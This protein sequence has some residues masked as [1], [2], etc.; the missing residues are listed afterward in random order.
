[1]NVTTP[2]YFSKFKDATWGNQSNNSRVNW[3]ITRYAD[4]LLMQSEALYRINAND[5][6]RF[7]GINLVRARVMPG[8]ANELNATNTPTPESFVAALVN[9]RGWELCME[10][11]RRWDL[12]RLGSIR[13]VIQTIKNIDTKSN[14]PLLPIPDNEKALNPNL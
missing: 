1:M 13:Q 8:A 5:P 11:H 12:I 4:V 3:L 14:N 2:L 6:N 7:N 9:E 10:G